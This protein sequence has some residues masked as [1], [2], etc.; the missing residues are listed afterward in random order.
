MIKFGECV[1]CV[2]LEETEPCNECTTG[3]LFESNEGEEKSLR[4]EFVK[5]MSFE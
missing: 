2:H 3:E 5:E 4:F 1:D